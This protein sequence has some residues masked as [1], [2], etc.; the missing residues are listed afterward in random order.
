MDVGSFLS[1]TL[2]VFRIFAR[3][4]LWGLGLGAMTLSVF[5]SLIGFA[6]PRPLWRVPRPPH[7]PL[8]LLLLLLHLPLLSGI[9]A[10]AISPVRGF[11]LL[12]A[13]VY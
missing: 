8:W 9:V 5:R 2:V 3:G 10:L 11:P 6:F 12:W 4:F 7:L 1:Q 13:V